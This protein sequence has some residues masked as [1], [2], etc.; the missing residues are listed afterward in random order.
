MMEQLIHEVTA[1]I[2]LAPLSLV[3]Y[4]SIKHHDRSGLAAGVLWSCAIFFGTLMQLP[5]IS[6]LFLTPL[7]FIVSW[8]ILK[9][10]R[11]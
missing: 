7:V 2:R 10:H 8:H 6:A 9:T 4:S 11:R 3:I 5:Y 1:Y